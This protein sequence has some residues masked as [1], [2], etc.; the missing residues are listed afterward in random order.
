[1]GSPALLMKAVPP[2]PGTNENPSE[3]GA[4]GLGFRARIIESAGEPVI[5]LPRARDEVGAL[6]AWGERASPARRRRPRHLAGRDHRK[7]GR[8]QIAANLTMMSRPG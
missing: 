2:R 3:N 4:L 6:A 1:M 7:C 5:G 8:T